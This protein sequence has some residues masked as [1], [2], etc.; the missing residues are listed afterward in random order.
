MS[1]P[2]ASAGIRIRWTLAAAGPRFRWIPV[3]SST[4]RNLSQPHGAV[5]PPRRADATVGHVHL[6]SR[7]MAAGWNIPAPV[8]RPVR[9][10]A[11]HVAA[12]LLVD[13]DRHPPVLSRGAGRRRRCST[14]L[15]TTLG[16]YLDM[17]RYGRAFR[18]DHLLPMARRDLVRAAD[19]ML[20]YPAAASSA[21]TTTRTV[22]SVATGRSGAP[23]RRQPRLCRR[24]TR[25]VSRTG[26]GSACGERG[27][28]SG[29]T[30]PASRSGRP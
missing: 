26:S 8:R 22:A 23:Y 15:H 11:Q 5:R 21:S 10:K 19:A 14:Q 18:D 25:V 2:R 6:R 28:A 30:G 17:Q 4:T 12:A 13:A 3:S 27:A 29:G 9:A 7:S 20:A 24:L 1:A 16:D